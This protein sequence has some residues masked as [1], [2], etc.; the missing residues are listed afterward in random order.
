MKQASEAIQF[1]RKINVK[2]E[3]YIFVTFNLNIYFS[4]SSPE[5]LL[6]GE[7]TF[8]PYKNRIKLNYPS[9]T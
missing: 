1:K 8:N 7:S 4:F 6:P 9:I 5:N 2:N 3:N